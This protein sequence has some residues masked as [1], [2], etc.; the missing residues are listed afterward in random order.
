MYKK[1]KYTSPLSFLEI[2]E[3]ER[4]LKLIIGKHCSLLWLNDERW[5]NPKLSGESDWSMFSFER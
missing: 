5:L 3:L 1:G 4:D 2:Q